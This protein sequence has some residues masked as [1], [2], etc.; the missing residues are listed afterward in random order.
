MHKMANMFTSGRKSGF[1][2]KVSQR[3]GMTGSSFLHLLVDIS[4]CLYRGFLSF[5]NAIAIESES[6]ASLNGS[7]WR[8]FSEATCPKLR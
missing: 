6:R 4:A 3:D 2:H 5:E 1:L 7:L 8:L